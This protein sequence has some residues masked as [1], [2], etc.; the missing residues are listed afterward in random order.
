M[1]NIQRNFFIENILMEAGIDNINFSKIPYKDY[2]A[3]INNNNLS[4]I[5]LNGIELKILTL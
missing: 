2:I 4:L 5:F 3:D 1:Y